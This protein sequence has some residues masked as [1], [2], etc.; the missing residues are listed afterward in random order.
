MHIHFN[1]C[2]YIQ[3]LNKRNNVPPN[4]LKSRCNNGQNVQLSDLVD[5]GVQH[6]G[7]EEVP[8]NAAVGAK[9]Q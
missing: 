3:I 7:A 1:N 9:Q 2:Q 6:S 4:S 5:E 8:G